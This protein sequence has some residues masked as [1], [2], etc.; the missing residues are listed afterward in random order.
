MSHKQRITIM[1]SEEITQKVRNIQT[2]QMQ[3]RNKNISFSVAIEELIKK[4]L[5]C[6]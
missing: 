1:L 6:S 5:K 3:K 4:G 2:K